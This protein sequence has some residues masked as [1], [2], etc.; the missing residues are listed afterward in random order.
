MLGC[1]H[2]KAVLPTLPACGVVQ[3]SLRRGGIRTRQLDRLPAVACEGQGCK[4][5]LLLYL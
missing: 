5:K 1:P 4:L 3:E 2:L